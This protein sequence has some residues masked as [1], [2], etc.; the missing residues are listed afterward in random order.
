MTASDSVS[1]C[2]FRRTLEIHQVTIAFSI[3]VLKQQLP[4]TACRL[5]NKDYVCFI[6][7]HKDLHR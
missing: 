3:Y 2:V 5:N 7:D 4:E 1:L 6:I